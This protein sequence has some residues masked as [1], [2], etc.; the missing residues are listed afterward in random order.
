MINQMPRLWDLDS[1]T[2]GRIIGQFLFQSEESLNLVLRRSPWSF[3]EWMVTVHRWSPNLPEEAQ[4][5]IPFW[6]QIRGIPLQF[7]TRGMIE[8]IGETPF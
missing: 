6:I 7:L 5:V 2:T 3:A 8:Y 4:K 1:S